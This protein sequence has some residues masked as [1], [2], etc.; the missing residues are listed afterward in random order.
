[1]QLS[2]LVEGR[3]APDAA[4]NRATP[5]PRLLDLEKTPSLFE[6]GF[7]GMAF[8]LHGVSLTLQIRHLVSNHGNSKGSHE[9]GVAHQFGVVD[10]VAGLHGNELRPML[11]SQVFA[12]FAAESEESVLCR[13]QITASLLQL[14]GDL[15]CPIDQSRTLFQVLLEDGPAIVVALRAFHGTAPDILHDAFDFMQRLHERRLVKFL[16]TLVL[17]NNIQNSPL[18]FP[19]FGMFGRFWGCRLVHAVLRSV[20]RL[21]RIRRL[22]TACGSGAGCGNIEAQRS[23]V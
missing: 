14:C 21:V 4:I 15:V 2:L 6:F 13:S 11:L 18:S 9:F 10:H 5:M 16:Q 8:M 17:G 19:D 3:S 22:L 23:I 12:R 1:M 20:R 7:L